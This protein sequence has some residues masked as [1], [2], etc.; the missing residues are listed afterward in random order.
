MKQIL[1]DDQF[2]KWQR[3]AQRKKQ[4]RKK[5]HHRRR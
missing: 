2:E 3:L 5:K 4:S 1:T